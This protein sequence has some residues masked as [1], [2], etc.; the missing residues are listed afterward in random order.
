MATP[1]YVDG[2]ESGREID[3]TGLVVTDYSDNDK[4]FFQGFDFCG[5]HRAIPQQVFQGEN[6]CGRVDVF[7]M[8]W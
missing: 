7:R 5:Y 8:F 6:D 1:T 4:K 2:Y 3:G